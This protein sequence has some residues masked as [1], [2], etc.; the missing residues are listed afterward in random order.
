MTKWQAS[1]LLAYGLAIALIMAVPVTGMLM[2]TAEEVQ[3]EQIYKKKCGQCH[4]PDL[5]AAW[6]Q[7]TSQADIEKVIREGA[8]KMP[9]Y[10]TKLTDEEIKTVAAYTRKLY[11][12]DKE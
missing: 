8:G 2:L 3:G 11:G 5:K 6:K 10:A 9:K 12:V 7:G 1:N 4:G